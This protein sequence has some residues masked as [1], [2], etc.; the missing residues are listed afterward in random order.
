MPT[1]DPSEGYAGLQEWSQPLIF[2]RLLSAYRKI[3][4]DEALARGLTRL[5][6]RVWRALINGDMNDFAAMREILVVAL[7][8]CSLTL[9]HLAD[10]DE[11][12]MIE[13]VDVVI[14][15][16]NRSQRT[17]RAYHLALVQLAGRLAPA[18]AAA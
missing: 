15:R 14:T 8:Q 1:T 5:H 10:V 16:Y 13:L 3:L 12:T 11:E 9:D 4:P 17:A 6:A 7:Q 2:D 18:R